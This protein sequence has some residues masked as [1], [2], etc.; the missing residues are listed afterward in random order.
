MER[1]LGDERIT[2]RAQ[3]VRYLTANYTHADGAPVSELL[4]GDACDGT[5][6]KVEIEKAVNVFG[7]NVYYV[8]DQIARREGWTE[9]PEEPD[10]E[11]A[12]GGETDD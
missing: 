10:D 11:T 6:A 12:E 3:V 8:G 4:A 9:I 2:G 1:Y 5:A 7:S